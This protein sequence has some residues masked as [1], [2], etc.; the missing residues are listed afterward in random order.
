VREC[1][2]GDTITDTAESG[3]IPS[4]GLSSVKPMVF[5]GM[6]RSKTTIITICAKRSKSSN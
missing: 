6:Y 1:R 5:A 3:F 4:A 2:V